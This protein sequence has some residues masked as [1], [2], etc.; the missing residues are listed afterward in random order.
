[1]G[2]A[3][4]GLQRFG[5]TSLAAHAAARLAPQVASVA[6]SA[7]RHLADYE[8]LGW[9][10]LTDA[11]A[12]FAGP[13]A[14]ILAGLSHCTLPCLATVACDAPCFPADLVA[15]LARALDAEGA[16]IAM[17]ATREDGEL[18]PQPVFSL[19]RASLGPSVREALASGEHKLGRWAASH[20]RVL[21][22]FD[23]TEAF[24]NANTAEE[25]QRLR[26]AFAD[27]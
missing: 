12:E 2:G 1:M 25:L 4:K 17:A 18:R 21:V 22:P 20:R 6:I 24:A 9:P 5:P 7:N 11:T 19:M 3:D 10:V 8:A 23:A 26:Q 13:L 16:E 27:G 14:G 15:R